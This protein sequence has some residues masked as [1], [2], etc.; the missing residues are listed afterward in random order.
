MCGEIQRHRIT[1]WPLKDQMWEDN[2]QTPY[3]TNSNYGKKK[4]EPKSLIGEI[5][6]QL[7]QIVLDTISDF[8]KFVILYCLTLDATLSL[9]LFW[10]QSWKAWRHWEKWEIEDCCPRR[11]LLWWVW[12]WSFSRKISER[13]TEILLW[14]NQRDQTEGERSF[15]GKIRDEALLWLGSL[16]AS[17]TI[18]TLGL[19]ERINHPLKAVAVQICGKTSELF[20]NWHIHIFSKFVLFYCT[21]LSLLCFKEDIV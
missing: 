1:E 10:H 16:V 20:K 15:S 6:N 21:D 4:K 7:W 5:R 8:G 17:H 2:N 12:C 13:E 11:C 3:L 9:I 18:L 14:E 19:E